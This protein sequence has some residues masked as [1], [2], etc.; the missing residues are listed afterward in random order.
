MIFSGYHLGLHL[1]NSTLLDITFDREGV[2]KNKVNCKVVEK[3]LNSP[4]GSRNSI[5]LVEGS[6]KP[7]QKETIK[8]FVKQPKCPD[9]NFISSLLN[10]KYV[11]EIFR[12]AKL[13]ELANMEGYD[14]FQNLL[15]LKYIESVKFVKTDIPLQNYLNIF[16]E[17]LAGIFNQ[18]HSVSEDSFSNY[19]NKFGYRKPVLFVLSHRDIEETYAESP[20]YRR[21]VY[22]LL[23]KDKYALFE[24]IKKLDCNWKA[25]R[26]VH[27]DFKF[28]HTLFDKNHTVKSIV[29]WE[30]AD[31]GDHHWDLASIC[32]EIII[33]YLYEDAPVEDTLRKCL[34]IFQGFLAKYTI[35]YVGKKLEK[36]LG[37]LFLHKHYHGLFTQ[38]GI[39]NSYATKW[40]QIAKDL[41]TGT[42]NISIPDSNIISQSL[43][44][45]SSPASQTPDDISPRK[46]EGTSTQFDE[47]SE[48]IVKKYPKAAPPQDDLRK[49]IYGWFHSYFDT[50]NIIENKL[51]NLKHIRIAEPILKGAEAYFEDSWWEVEGT[52]KNNSL[53]VRKNSER[54]VAEPGVFLYV[55]SKTKNSD[56]SMLNKSYIKT[57]YPHFMV[58]PNDANPDSEDLWVLSKTQVRQDDI[59]WLRFYFHLNE[60]QEGI[61]LFLNKITTLLNERNVP[62]Q[63]KLRNALSSY[64]RA[65]VAILFV[66][67][68]HFIA[69]LDVI[70]YVH[71]LLSPKYLRAFIPKFTSQLKC[72]VRGKLA[73]MK[74]VGFA[75]NPVSSSESFGNWRARLIAEIAIK[76]WGSNANELSEALK[77]GMNAKGFNIYKM[78]RNPFPSKHEAKYNTFD[79]LGEI[80]IL[81]YHY[82]GAEVFSPAFKYFN[83]AR[84]IAFTICREAVWYGKYCTWFAYKKDNNGLAFFE[85]L[86]SD[87]L[88]GVALFLSGMAL[89]YPNDFIFKSCVDGIMKSKKSF[90]AL[91]DD[92]EKKYK[93]ICNL[94]EKKLP[95]TS[96]PLE[97]SI[98]QYNIQDIQDT[99]Q[100]KRLGDAII[101]QYIEANLPLPN[102]YGNQSIFNAEFNP[103]ITHG[104]AAI[105][106]FFLML[107]DV[108]NG[109]IEPLSKF[110][111]SISIVVPSIKLEN[112]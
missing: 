14:T 89:V 111:T 13:S 23:R 110:Y 83:A 98:G 24:N 21:E 8:Y 73:I 75:E 81:N 53:I 9:T 93:F 10:E 2:V 84:K 16:L 38:I 32:Y 82:E 76:N 25:E 20:K 85:T 99:V 27:L 5:F 59:N 91:G 7:G 40:L 94:L 63:L 17:N 61:N 35:G 74:G 1:L 96:I 33:F 15:F 77:Q 105:G 65:D 42:A 79:D 49:F 3:S 51:K 101:A 18:V 19:P 71:S 103:T 12:D 45:L 56:G 4:I 88:R 64:Y 67:R 30:M 44:Q 97:G 104:L 109:R 29:D 86:S 6:L 54:R 58:R 60:K 39:G 50:G 80:P 72:K 69:S 26:L 92:L 11:Y 100:A 108:G 37:V 87:E 46:S 31:M 95:S 22:D 90:N 106:Y 66:H 28:E 107:A 43:T 41:I 68:L 112:T 78:Y 48:L 52:S 57:C 36:Y 70:L 34:S 55:R 102:A 62:F 47:L